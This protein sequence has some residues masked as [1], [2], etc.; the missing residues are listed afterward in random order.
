[1]YRLSFTLECLGIT[2]NCQ[3]ERFTTFYESEINKSL[4]ASKFQTTEIVTQQETSIGW[5]PVDEVET[6]MICYNRMQN[7]KEF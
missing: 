2:V 4:I 7:D 1:M 3:T 5:L 6:A